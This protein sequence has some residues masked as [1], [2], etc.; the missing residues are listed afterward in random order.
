MAGLSAVGSGAGAAL[1]KGFGSLAKSGPAAA[2]GVVVLIGTLSA[3]A[4]VLG[5][6]VGIVT[7]LAATIVSSLVDALAVAGSAIMAVVA[8]GGLLPAAFMSMTNAQRDALVSAVAPLR[9]VM[10]GIGQVIMREVVPAF[11]TWSRNLQQA[12]FLIPPMAQTM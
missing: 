2:V 9:E 5:G 6:L 11:E 3:M 12:V 7:A 10:T 4:T 8:A 1:A